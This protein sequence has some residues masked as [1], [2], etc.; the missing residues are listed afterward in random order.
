[1]TEQKSKGGSLENQPIDAEYQVYDDNGGFVREPGIR[2]AS[3]RI[4]KIHKVSMDSGVPQLIGEGAK[5]TGKMV[6]W[7]IKHTVA[8][9]ADGVKFALEGISDAN[10]TANRGFADTRRSEIAGRRAASKLRAKRS[11]GGTTF[12]DNRSYTFVSEKKKKRP[13]WVIPSKEE[14]MMERMEEYD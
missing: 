9:M 3:R 7:T 12:V 8:L 4:A 2:R 14:E 10:R 1:M 11:S 13:F 6:L 5:S